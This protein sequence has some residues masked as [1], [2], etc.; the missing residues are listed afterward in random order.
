MR[1]DVRVCVDS[2]AHYAANIGRV[3]RAL[4]MLDE[5]GF[6]PELIVNLTFEGFE[7]YMAEREARMKAHR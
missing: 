6:P 7:K 3:P 2:D 5:I 4:E 1:Y